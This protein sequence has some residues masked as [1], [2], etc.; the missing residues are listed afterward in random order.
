ME[1]VS[2]FVSDI[3]ITPTRLWDLLALTG[4]AYR[5]MPGHDRQFTEMV[6]RRLGRWL[7]WLFMPAYLATSG[8]GYKALVN[9]R[10]AG[11]AFLQLRA[12]SGYIYNVS[13]NQAY[14]RQGVATRLMAY[15]AAETASEGRT[16]LALQV[17]EGNQGAQVLYQGLGYHYYHTDYLHY[18]GPPLAPPPLTLGTAIEPLGNRYHAHY[19]AYADLERGHGDGW[20]AAVVAADYPAGPPAGG[21]HWRCLVNGRE[22][23]Y[24]WIGGAADQAMLIL[25][26][27]PQWWGEPETVAFMGQLLA[28]W[29]VARPSKV[30]L[31]VGSSGHQA[32]VSHLL[33]PLGFQTVPQPRLLMLKPV[34][35]WHE[36]KHAGW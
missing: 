28:V 22:A 25:L 14:R 19:H 36:T 11:C 2:D 9:G 1:V 5:N 35:D 7:G 34:A 17:D 33:A 32:A 3:V 13:V 18:D 24:G 30:D 4:M 15:L 12:Q 27:D 10:L 6:S 20:A 23:G 29:G 21:S 8:R 31:Y 26:L 16:W